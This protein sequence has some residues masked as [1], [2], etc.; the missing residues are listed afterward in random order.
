MSSQAAI[1]YEEPIHLDEFSSRKEGEPRDIVVSRE[2]H[3]VKVC[4]CP[5]CYVRGA[6]AVLD[7]IKGIL[8]IK[9]GETTTDKKYTLEIATNIGHCVSGP[10]VSIDGH[11]YHSL[12]P[13][14]VLGLLQQSEV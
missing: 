10:N 4:L 3:V 14:K 2:N 11:C 13:L 8:N 12:T 7:A 1:G 6:G 9:P 5:P